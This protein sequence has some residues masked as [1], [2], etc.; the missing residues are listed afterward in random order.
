[1]KACALTLTLLCALLS[2]VQ[3]L[4]DACTRIQGV[5]AGDRVPCDGV[6]WTSGAT[7]EAIRCKTVDTPRLIAD[8]NLCV[9]RADLQKTALE[10]KLAAAQGLADQRAHELADV[11]AQLRADPPAPPWYAAPALWAIVGLAAGGAGG[12]YFARA[13]R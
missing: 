9:Q 12:Y 10:R 1:M 8:L 4:G 3:A 11:Q 2:P 5:S 6:L 13:V 7:A